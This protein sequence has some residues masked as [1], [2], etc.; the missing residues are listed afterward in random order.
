MNEAGTHDVGMDEARGRRDAPVRVEHPSACTFCSNSAS[1]QT[2]IARS[3]P[4]RI[5]RFCWS[6]CCTEHR[7]PR[8][9]HIQ[10]RVS[11]ETHDV[12]SSFYCSISKG[13][14]RRRA[15]AMSGDIGI[16]HARKTQTNAI[17][18]RISTLSRHLCL[19]CEFDGR[20][21]VRPHGGPIGNGNVWTKAHLL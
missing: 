18:R 6:F 8:L 16:R 9:C 3:L 10:P 4:G 17:V 13:K 2:G 19:S 5:A 15:T 1:A 11:S 7:S 14:V 21:I 20:I 12:S